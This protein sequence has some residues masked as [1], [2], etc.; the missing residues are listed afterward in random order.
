MRAAE[1]ALRIE[2]K[3]G[4]G[5]L[6]D[7][8]LQRLLWINIPCGEIHVFDPSKGSDSIVCSLATSI[9]TVVQRERGGLLAAAG[10]GFRFVDEAGG[11]STLVC[12]PERH[13][14]TNRF[15]D[16]KCDPAGRMWAG[17]MDNAEAARG[18]GSLYCLDG[19][20]TCRRMEE[21]VTISN[22]IAWSPDGKTMYYTDT[23]THV[24]W[25]YDYDNGTGSIKNRRVCVEIANGE[26]GPDGF[27]VDAEGTLWVA[28]WGGWQV[29]RY[30]PLTGR[31][32]GQI[33]VP[34]A[35]V[36]S[37]ALGGAN[38]DT[39]YITTARKGISDDELTNQP[40]AG[41]LFAAK[42]DA[43]GMKANRFA[44]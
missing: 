44:G 32:L 13:R 41:C 30:D 14:P 25:A 36:S 27:T 24:I 16:G 2:A 34:A 23:P 31:K 38:L 3:L 37:C 20:M 4:E 8:R 5:A 40:L 21:G 39:L 12:S 29:G 17:T 26:G 19:D 28:Q 18:A 35:H 33:S 6:W 43:T 11:A 7:D 9:G 42:V 1:L 10:D 15:N 22:G